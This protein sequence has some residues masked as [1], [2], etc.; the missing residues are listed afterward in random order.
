MPPPKTSPGARA[1]PAST[2][3][4]EGKGRP[5]PRLEACPVITHDEAFSRIEQ[6]GCLRGVVLEAQDDGHRPQYAAFLLFSWRKEYTVLGFGA[7]ERPRLFRDLDRVLAL[8]R[9][10][11]AFMGTVA[12]RLANDGP[13]RQHSWRITHG[14]DFSRSPAAKRPPGTRRT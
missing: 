5:L 7:A 9:C 11:Y 1:R 3:P 6:G 8:V 12:L 13:P 10:E 2:K 4:A 14:S